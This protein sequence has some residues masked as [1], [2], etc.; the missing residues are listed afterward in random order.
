MICL[1]GLGWGGPGPPYSSPPSSLPLPFPHKVLYAPRQMDMRHRMAPALSHHTA[2]P[3]PQSLRSCRAAPHV[4]AP[5]D[6]TLLGARQH[7]PGQGPGQQLWST[8]T[9]V[10]AL[11]L[12][13]GSGGHVGTGHGTLPLVCTCMCP[14]CVC[15]C[16]LLCWYEARMAS[17]WPGLSPMAT[18]QKPLLGGPGG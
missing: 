4:C 15:T 9:T 14:V 1:W 10:P 3:F 12:W 8:I 11:L 17:R 16:A 5:W 13:P 7:W 6:S 2:A 18:S